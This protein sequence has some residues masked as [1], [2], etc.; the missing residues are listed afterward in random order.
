MAN[1]ACSVERKC[2]STGRLCAADDR[3]CQS[4]AV[5]DQLEIICERGDPA[6]Y[7]YCPP[8]AEQRDGPVVWI[9]LGVAVL[10]AAFGGIGAWLVFRRRV[11]SD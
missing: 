4:A 5:A 6:V 11:A 1:E 3:A 2:S 9:L 10:I 7:V 8:G